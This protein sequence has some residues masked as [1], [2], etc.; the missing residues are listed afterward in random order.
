MT[1]GVIIAIWGRIVPLIAAVVASDNLLIVDPNAGLEG[2]LF[3]STGIE[4]LIAF[5]IASSVVALFVFTISVVTIPMMLRDQS[6]GAISAMVLS[7]QVVMENKATMAAWALTIGV[8]LSI[9]IL[10]FGLGMLIVMPLLGYASWHAFNDLVE[11]EE[12]YPAINPCLLYT[13]D[14]ADEP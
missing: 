7:Y 4:F 9:G 13:S 8:L 11:I 2:F 1:L 14:A 5:F 6:V 10:S 3:S 12:E